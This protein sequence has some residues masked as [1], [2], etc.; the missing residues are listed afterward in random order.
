MQVNLRLLHP[1]GGVRGAVEGLHECRQ[2]LR[3]AEAHIADLDLVCLRM[4]AHHDFEFLAAWSDGAYIEAVNNAEALQ[5]VRNV[6]VEALAVF[7]GTACDAAVLL[8][9]CQ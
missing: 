2:D 4:G 1:D 8:R 6:C 3:H 5:P 9:G 7:P